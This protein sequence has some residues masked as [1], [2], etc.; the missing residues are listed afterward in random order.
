MLKSYYHYL[1]MTDNEMTLFRVSQRDQ[2]FKSNG[3]KYDL[4]LICAGTPKVAL[5]VTNSARVIGGHAPECVLPVFEFG[6]SRRTRKR[7]MFAF[8]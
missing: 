4:C 2:M 6:S 3:H 5:I 7:R 1:F 8:I